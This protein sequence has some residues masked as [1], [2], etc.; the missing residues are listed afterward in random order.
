MS[1]TAEKII[2]AYRR[3]LTYAANHT[4]TRL[5]VTILLCLAFLGMVVW[6]LLFAAPAQFPSQTLLHVKKGTT[7]A[8][9]ASELKEKHI[10]NYAT[11]FEVIARLSVPEGV[12]V[13]GEYSFSRPESVLSVA[14][15]LTS[16]DFQVAPVKVR[17]AEGMS[18]LHITTL[19][20]NQL[21]DFDADTFYDLA[22]PKEGTLF[23]DT[24]F[25]LPGQD[26]ELV[27]SAMTD[28]FA[29]HIRDASVAAAI[30]TFGKPV[31]EV[32]TMAS[33]LE[34]EAAET[35][36][37]RIISGILWR[38]IKN[39]MPLQVDAAFT[40]ILNKN[41][42]TL[43]KKDLQTDSP[44]NTYT[45]KGLP[46]TPIGNPSMNAIMAAVQPLTTSYVFYLSDREGN[47]HYATTYA[48]HLANKAKYLSN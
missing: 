36:D 30:A 31:N 25:F 7:L 38:R 40:Y 34:K 6:S 5:A 29:V 22:L 28:N 2:G 24:Y 15:R 11:L 4:R 39:N 44:Y 27:L 14:A 47:M 37:R 16:G 45:N 48:Q 12:I 26:P 9:I 8:V 10:I 42:Y 20:R 19:L 46:P 41:T 33:I 32:L 13:A 18:V 35:Q 21:P 3:A 1:S 23:P 43:T 17:I